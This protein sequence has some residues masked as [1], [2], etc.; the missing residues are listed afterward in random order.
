M[1]LHVADYLVLRDDILDED[2]EPILDR[3]GH[4]KTRW[5]DFWLPWD[6]ISPGY[7]DG[8]KWLTFN[9]PRHAVPSEAVLLSYE[10]G[11]TASPDGDGFRIEYEIV[12]KTDT[13]EHH[14]R[15]HRTTSLTTRGLWARV[16]G[17]WL[18]EHPSQNT[19]LFRVRETERG[20]TVGRARF[21]KIILWFQREV[22]EP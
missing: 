15:R 17:R 14:V 12:I 6:Q 1:A 8:E 21:S 7:R 9:L 19:L 22:G 4:P 20:P 3:D 11:P 18:L 13:D 5:A 10:L 16:P 2:G